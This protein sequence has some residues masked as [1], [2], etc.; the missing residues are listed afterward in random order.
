MNILSFVIILLIGTNVYSQNM[1]SEDLIS[2]DQV[3]P[4]LGE[5]GST[6]IPE[7]RVLPNL[8]LSDI[9]LLEKIK[10]SRKIIND[11]KNEKIEEVLPK[12]KPSAPLITEIEIIQEDENELAV[13][14]EVSTISSAIEQKSYQDT[15]GGLRV[16]TRNLKY[17]NSALI[18]QTITLPSGSS[19]LA[20]LLGGLEVSSSEVRIDVRIDYAFL[21]PNKAVVE[22]NG[23][24][25]WVKFRADFST[26]RLYGTA[27]SISCKA[28]N[29]RTFDL[30][31]VGHIKDEED[32]YIGARG[33]LIPNGK[34][35]ASVLGF[36]QDGAT[37]Y[38]DALAKAQTTT[39]VAPGSGLGSPA[40][41]EN[42]T[43]DRTAYIAG[44]TIAGASGK[45]L[46][47][48]VDHYT[49][50]APTIAVAP[51]KK[52]FISIEGEVQIPEMFFE[53]D[54]TH[55]TNTGATM[56]INKG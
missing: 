29:G 56:T 45:F 27:Y 25:A 51:G 50:L 55:K 1:P 26:E 54:K 4:S 38:G 41:G 37:A 10:E 32:E 28:P 17:S 40:T 13:T 36:L 48:W 15:A 20:T 14:D 33:K 18:P 22:M 47:W 7:D 3:T 11:V 2:T 35:A 9:S 44:Q 16:F 8:N 5:A 24:I 34:L 52:I 21:G 12:K 19:A 43:N 49:Q 31:I 42:V 23:C 30:P 39:T 6:D 53:D 46:N